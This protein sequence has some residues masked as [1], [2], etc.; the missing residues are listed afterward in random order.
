MASRVCTY[1][2]ACICMGL[3]WALRIK[4]IW[5]QLGLHSFPSRSQ[6]YL[7]SYVYCVLMSVSKQHFQGK[8]PLV[9]P[10]W[11][12]R[13]ICGYEWGT[14]TKEL[15]QVPPIHLFTIAFII[16]VQ[17]LYACTNV[18]ANKPPPVALVEYFTVFAMRCR[19][20]HISVCCSC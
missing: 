10:V 2:Q 13:L 6:S 19:C 4:V 15:L 8:D 12:I 20:H 5:K 9:E 7:W 11:L 1:M 18:S 17:T 14:K 16:E 3:F